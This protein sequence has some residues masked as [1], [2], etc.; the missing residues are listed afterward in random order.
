MKHVHRDRMRA[1]C[2][3]CEKGNANIRAGLH[4]DELR[5]VLAHRRGA[6]GTGLVWPRHRLELLQQMLVL[7]HQCPAGV[8]EEGLET[9]MRK[10]SS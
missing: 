9:T 5:H 8:H 4:E 2:K 7:W 6:G 10:Y 1:S 3:L